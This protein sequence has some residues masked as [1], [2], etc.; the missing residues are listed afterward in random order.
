MNSKIALITGITGQ[1]GSYLVEF[2]L[3]KGYKVHGIKRRS[4]SYNTQRI[5]HIIREPQTKSNFHLHYGDL[6][7]SL[8]LMNIIKKLIPLKFII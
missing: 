1:D 7:D 2:L 5:D 6:T 8:S 3:S 4:S